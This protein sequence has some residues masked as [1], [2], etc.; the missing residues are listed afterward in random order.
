MTIF[1]E[2]GHAPIASRSQSAGALYTAVDK[3]NDRPRA[4]GGTRCCSGSA[5][6]AAASFESHCPVVVA[7]RHH[8][9]VADLPVERYRLLEPVARFGEVF[10]EECNH[11]QIVRRVADT[12]TIIHSQCNASRML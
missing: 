7:K 9:R 8:P 11:S 10:Q 6:V 1:D 3:S 4:L 5:A 12:S 2:A